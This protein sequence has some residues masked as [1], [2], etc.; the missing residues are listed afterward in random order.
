MAESRLVPPDLAAELHDELM[1]LKAAR[2][3]N[4][5]HGTRAG[6]QRCDEECQVCHAEMLLDFLISQIPRG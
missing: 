3:L 1:R 6:P 4:P 2:A 5:K